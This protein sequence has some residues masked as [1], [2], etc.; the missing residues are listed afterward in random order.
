MVRFSLLSHE[1]RQRE[2]DFVTRGLGLA[3]NGAG[4]QSS[5]FGNSCHCAGNTITHSTPTK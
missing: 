3:Y 4:R 5:R 1:A 2:F